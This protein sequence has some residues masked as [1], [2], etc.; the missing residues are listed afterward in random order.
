MC[1]FLREER[2]L[3]ALEPDQH[4]FLEM[5]KNPFPGPQARKGQFLLMWKAPKDRTNASLGLMWA[6]KSIFQPTMEYFPS[7]GSL[8]TM[9]QG[10]EGGLNA[11]LYKP[12]KR[13]TIHDHKVMLAK[14]AEATLVSFVNQGA[15]AK[16]EDSIVGHPTI[17]AHCNRERELNYIRRQKLKEKHPCVSS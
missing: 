2:L 7:L 4:A 1:F 3:H 10:R 12:S 6:H 15:R 9:Y 11:H 16:E 5:E 13:W 8:S 14:V 17:L